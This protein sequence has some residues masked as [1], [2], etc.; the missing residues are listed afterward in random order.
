ML[1]GGGALTR[2]AT[3]A[4]GTKR[5]S[6]F[7]SGAAKLICKGWGWQP[8]LLCIA[9]APRPH[10]AEQPGKQRHAAGTGRFKVQTPHPL[11]PVWFERSL[12]VWENSLRIRSFIKG[13][14][15]STALNTHLHTNW[16]WRG[17]KKKGEKK[18]PGGC[19]ALYIVLARFM[20]C[21]HQQ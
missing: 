9:S 18:K 16:G 3:S 17:K 7:Q 21:G 6:I 14:Y 15:F 4:G 11:T 2:S 19:L 10:N 1:F 5:R 13:H 20:S 8:S 12:G